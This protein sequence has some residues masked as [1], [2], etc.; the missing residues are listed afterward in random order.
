MNSEKITTNTIYRS[1]VPVQHF[2]KNIHGNIFESLIGAI[3][4]DKATLTAKA[5]SKKK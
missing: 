2:W 5:L 4:L 1:K 3:Y